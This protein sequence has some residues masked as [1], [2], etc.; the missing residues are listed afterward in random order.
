M[1]V[2]ITHCTIRGL[3]T[4]ACGGTVY[5][6]R[7][8]CI[9]GIVPSTNRGQTRQTR[10]AWQTSRNQGPTRCLCL[11]VAYHKD[12]RVL[13]KALIEGLRAQ[14]VANRPA[15]H[16]VQHHPVLLRLRFGIRGWGCRFYGCTYTL[17]L[18]PPAAGPLP[19]RNR[20]HIHSNLRLE[21]AAPGDWRCSG[22]AS[23]RNVPAAGRSVARRRCGSVVRCS[24]TLCRRWG[25]SPQK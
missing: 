18:L 12:N 21:T 14:L 10:R 16:V 11:C 24:A 25:I 17:S 22:G 7:H 5:T 13:R 6:S 2:S 3:P 1:Y 9:C 4:T 23:A 20:A 19:S 8:L 15:V